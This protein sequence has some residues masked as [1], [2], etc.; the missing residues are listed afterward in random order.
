MLFSVSLP[1]DCRMKTL[2][3]LNKKK[4]VSI[5]DTGFNYKN[6]FPQVG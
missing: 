4:P 6:G 2:V 3:F 5:A 1:S